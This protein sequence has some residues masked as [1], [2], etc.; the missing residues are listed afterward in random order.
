MGTLEHVKLLESKV[1]NAIGFVKRLTEENSRLKEETKGQQQRIE[2]LEQVIQGCKEDQARIEEGILS[3]LNRLNQF[4]DAMEEHLSQ[5]LTLTEQGGHENGGDGAPPPPSN[6][7][8]TN[9]T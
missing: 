2:E 3:A 9:H 8:E 5:V 7:T 1:D 6:T 4:E